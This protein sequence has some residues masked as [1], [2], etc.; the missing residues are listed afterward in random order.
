MS[1]LNLIYFDILWKI[2]CCTISEI[3]SNLF[4]DFEYPKAFLLIRSDL[5]YITKAIQV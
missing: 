5:L 3:K 4:F 1:I 2:S